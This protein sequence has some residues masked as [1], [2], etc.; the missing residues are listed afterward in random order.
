MHSEDG[1]INGEYGE[2]FISR[3]YLGDGCESHARLLNKHAKKGLAIFE[4]A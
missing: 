3:R 4:A 2:A 1:E